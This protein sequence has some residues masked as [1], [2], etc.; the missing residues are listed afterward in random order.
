MTIILFCLYAFQLLVSEKVLNTDICLFTVCRTSLS[1]AHI[2]TL[3]SAF[4][5]F[6]TIFG[7]YYLCIFQLVGCLQI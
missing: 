4:W 1:I 3:I 6:Y 7:W 5:N 2:A